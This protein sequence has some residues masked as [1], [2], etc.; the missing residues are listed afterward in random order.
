MADATMR[1]IEMLRMI[2]RQGKV[3][4]QQLCRSLSDLGFQTTERSVQRDLQSLS[5]RV[6]LVCDSSS[7]PHGWHWSRNTPVWNLPGLALSEAFAFQLLEKYSPELMPAALASQLKPYF[8]SAREQVNREVGSS[9]ARNWLQKV[10]IVSPSQPLLPVRASAEVLEA[11]HEA[12]MHDRC[13]KIRYRTAEAR[14][15]IVHPLGLIQQD[16]L[17]YCAVNFDGFSDVRL[18][19][20]HRIRH[21]L[22]LDKHCVKPL[23]FSLDQF[24]ADGGLGFGEVGKSIRLRIRLHDYA[25]EHLRETPLSTDQKHVDLGEG[26]AEIRATVQLT[27]RLRW[28]LLAF[29]PDVEVLAPAGLRKEIHGLLQAALSRYQSGSA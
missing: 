23:G 16:R 18:I 25:G 11:V 6:S 8:V 10:R 15:S 20:V 12:L 29:G 22:L 4:V 1:Q 5:A 3:T 19:A 28:W 2:P 26:S 21:A 7:K 9:R 24:I 27:R 17:L 14:E 13:L